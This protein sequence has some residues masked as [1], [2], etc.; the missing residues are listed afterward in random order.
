MTDGGTSFDR[1]LSSGRRNGSEIETQSESTSYE[2]DRHWRRHRYRP[3]RGRRGIRFPSGS[4]RRAARV[5]AY[6]YHGVFLD[7]ELGGNGHLHAGF[8]FVR[9]VRRKVCG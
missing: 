7:D 5:F 4:G 1:R 6:R 3:L 2:Y 8:R 9:N